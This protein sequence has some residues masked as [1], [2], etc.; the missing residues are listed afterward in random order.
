M[1]TYTCRYR[2][3][4]GQEQTVEV[5]ASDEL[6]ALLS[7]IGKVKIPTHRRTYITPLGCEEVRH[8]EVS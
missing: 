6:G 5:E 7:G 8:D 1:P 3:D 4:T 2:L